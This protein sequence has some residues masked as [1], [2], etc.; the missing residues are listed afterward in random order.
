MHSATVLFT[1]TVDAADSQTVFGVIKFDEN[2][3]YTS[4]P[5]LNGAGNRHQRICNIRPRLCEPSLCEPS[6]CGPCQ[7]LDWS[8]VG[9]PSLD[10]QDEFLL[11]A[12]TSPARTM[13]FDTYYGTLLVIDSAPTAQRVIINELSL[14]T[15]T[16]WMMLGGP[17][18]SIAFTSSLGVLTD[19]V[20]NL[21]LAS[22]DG[23]FASS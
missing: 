8:G 20:I 21:A 12:G 2:T 17:A 4:F 16:T 14:E 10:L 9:T 5:N 11:S 15:E 6:L 7:D 3:A 13:C 19:R 18:Q 23:S 22:T 1:C